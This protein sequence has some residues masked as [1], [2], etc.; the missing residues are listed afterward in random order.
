MSRKRVWDREHWAGFCRRIYEARRRLADLVG[1][2]PATKGF[3]ASHADAMLLVRNRLD[4]FL[5]RLE[6][7]YREQVGRRDGTGEFWD[8]TCGPDV[9]P[10]ARPPA[11][12]APVMPVIPPAEWVEIGREWKGI[13]R[14][15]LELSRLLLE[16]VP[17]NHR[18]KAAM[19]RLIRA[20]CFARAALEG[21]AH[22][23]YP[24]W[25]RVTRVFFGPDEPDA[26]DAGGPAF[27]LR[28]PRGESGVFRRISTER[29]A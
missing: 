22:K 18:A 28:T 11:V 12:V 29:S 23:Q 10:S 6:G 1:G 17:K 16:T 25:D 24:A 13:D 19:D 14:E 7:V 26:E 2:F 8:M 3:C 4:D 27:G 15:F 9:S 20:S 21:L 5:L